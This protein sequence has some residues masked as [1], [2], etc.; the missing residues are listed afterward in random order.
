MTDPIL[1]VGAGPTGL[2]AA[3]ELSRFGVQVRIIDH[4][5]GP[6]TTSRALGIQARTMELLEQRRLAEEFLQLGNPAG[7]G[8]IYGDG[9]RLFR[10]D[11]GTVHSRYN[12]LMNLSQAES[13]RILRDAITAQG[14]RIEWGTR[15]VGF[16]QDALAHTAN[17]VTATL[18]HKDG[19]LEVVHAPWLISAEGAHSSVRTTLGLSFEGTTN[20]RQYMLGD[21]CIDGDLP[22]T[23]FHIFG[24]VH[25]VIAP[26]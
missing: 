13:E 22:A 19:N 15:M 26:V 17:R 11:F 25:G 6:A 20:P 24:S 21:V 3:L 10:I 2:I 8:S 5:N 7:Y 12:Y 4:A 23:D 16:T 9:K 1:I 14:V 18:Q